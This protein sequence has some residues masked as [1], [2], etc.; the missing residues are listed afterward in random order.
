M[1]HLSH[2]TYRS[3]RCRSGFKRVSATTLASGVTQEDGSFAVEWKARKTDA[4]DN[5]AE[6]QA[7]FK[8]D[9]DHRTSVSK[10]YVVTIETKK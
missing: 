5:T 7:K 3:K 8:G 6:T 10:Q 9:E 2:G 1:L 4:F